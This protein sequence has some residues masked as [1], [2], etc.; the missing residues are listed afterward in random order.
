[1]TEVNMKD[2]SSSKALV[3]HRHVAGEMGGATVWCVV[4][5]D[6]FILECGSGGVSQQRA[7]IL[8][9]IINA[10]GPERLDQKHL[11]AEPLP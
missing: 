10:S 8:A 4:L 3:C 2:L 6:G 5:A 1:M 9:R 11:I 7:I